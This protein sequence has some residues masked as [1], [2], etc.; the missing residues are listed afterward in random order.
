MESSSLALGKGLN[1]L[2]GETGAGK[3][4][5]IGA[6]GLILGKRLDSSRIFNPDKK[7]VIEAR[8]QNIPSEILEDLSTGDA[9]DIEADNEILIRREASAN[10]KSRA[11]INDTPVTLEVL[12]ETTGRLVDLHGQH[13]N[14][15]LLNP[16]F[17]LQLLD[18]FA[19]IR[20]EVAAF[21]QLFKEVG[22]VANTLEDLRSNEKE[23]RQQLDYY[24]FQLQELEA[25]HLDPEADDNIEE[26]LNLLQN[27]GDIT[28]TLSRAS[29]GLFEDDQSLY[30]K[31]AEI[32]F[33]LQKPAEQS[34]EIQQVLEKLN[35]AEATLQD[36][37]H[38]LSAIGENIDLD[39][40]MLAELE[41]RSDLLNRLKMKFG[42]QNIAELQALEKEFAEKVL[43]YSS[44]EDQIQACENDLNKLKAK[45]IKEGLKI[46]KAR[47]KASAHLG[48]AVDK[49]L[50][51]L[52]IPDGKF[53]LAIHRT[54]ASDGMLEIEG[55]NIRPG[56]RGFNQVAFEIRTNKGME[57]GSLAKIASGGEISRVML[58]IKAALAER[59]A[60][61]V[62]IFDEIDTGISG[63][64]ANKVARV[65]Q[66]LSEKYQ[67]IAITHLPQIAGRGTTHFQISKAVLGKN[68]VSMV[69]K[70]S[71]ED[72]ILALAKMLS[73]DPP[74][75]SA[76]ENARELLGD[77]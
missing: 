30:N 50:D 62:L 31:L 1:I 58:A 8:F 27:A 21:H 61:P 32:T 3:S 6:I 75:T 10:G 15:Q 54:R 63:E 41:E 19:G 26:R 74:S 36:A 64:T 38:E 46:E 55:Q 68:T 67:L 66:T 49:L 20:S 59:A 28:D 4:L 72:R 39:P 60:L 51:G 43:G 25:A 29:Q 76:V 7:C 23:A 40:A 22:T 16:A 77:N 44:I 65:M 45:L 48:K 2:T 57:M 35:E 13:E 17:Q 52:G 53:Q 24:Q 69:A 34:Q 37:A 70:L 9:F 42:V 5:L 12:R 47:Q 18:N 14:Q 11:F 73:G 56:K 71:Q 33:S